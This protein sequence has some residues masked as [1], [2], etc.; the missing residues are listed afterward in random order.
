MVSLSALGQHPR[1]GRFFDVVHPFFWPVI[2]WTLNTV[3]RQYDASNRTEFLLGITWWGQVYIA[4]EGDLRPNPLNYRPI[5][6][7]FRL[8]TDECWASDLPTNLEALSPF[9]EVITLTDGLALRSLWRSRKGPLTSPPTP[10]RPPCHPGFRRD[11]KINASFSK[12]T[13]RPTGASGRSC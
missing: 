2:W 5:A 6:R 8:L 12:E 13:G 3:F 10:P 7:T 4:F 1:F 11:D 9:D